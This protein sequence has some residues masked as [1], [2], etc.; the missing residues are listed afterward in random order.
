MKLDEE[1]LIEACLRHDQRACK[2]LYDRFAPQMFGLCLRY[3][4]SYAAAQDALHDGF[5][6]VFNSLKTVKDPSALGSWIRSIMIYTVLNTVRKEPSTDM[7]NLSDI[8]QLADNSSYDDIFSTLD[9]HVILDAIQQLPASYRSA[10]NLCAI[11]GYTC[12]QASEILGIG[13]TTVRSNLFR[14]R[15]ILAEKLAPIMKKD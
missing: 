15:A 14:A 4:H 6:K 10:F 8:P 1:H 2:M 13:Q 9:I 12:S 7:E 11:E 3:T 5:I